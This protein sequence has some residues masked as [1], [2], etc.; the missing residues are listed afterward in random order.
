MLLFV[1]SACAYLAYYAYISWRH[2]QVLQ[3]HL[4]WYA[5]IYDRWNPGQARALRSPS[6]LRTM[7][8]AYIGM[9]ALVLVIAAVLAVQ[10]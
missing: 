10:G 4:S 9:F 6:H 2:P 8:I 7:R 5:R 1:F 3:S